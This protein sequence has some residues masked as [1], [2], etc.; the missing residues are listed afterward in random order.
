MDNTEVCGRFDM[1]W[2]M[3]LG[4]DV[5]DAKEL[6]SITVVIPRSTNGGCGVS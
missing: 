4:L 3:A 2:R 1:E 5:V 6:S